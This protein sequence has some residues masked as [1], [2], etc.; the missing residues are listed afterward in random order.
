M[1]DQEFSD[2]DANPKG[3]GASLIFGQIYPENCMK[4]KEIEPGGGASMA[5]PLD[6][7]MINLAIKKLNLNIQAQYVQIKSHKYI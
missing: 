3:G 2:G 1:A 4:M 7:P 6:P 5:P